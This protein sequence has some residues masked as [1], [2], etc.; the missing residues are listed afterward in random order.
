MNNFPHSKNYDKLENIIKALVDQLLTKEDLKGIHYKLN[1][2]METFRHNL[3][4]PEV[5]GGMGPFGSPTPDTRFFQ[6]PANPGVNPFNQRGNQMPGFFNSGDSFNGA[7][8]NPQTN[9][10]PSQTEAMKHPSDDIIRTP[11]GQI[12]VVKKPL[13]QPDEQY[14]RY[15]LNLTDPELRV[16]HHVLTPSG[17]ITLYYTTIDGKTIGREVLPRMPQQQTTSNSDKSNSFNGA[18]PGPQL[19]PDQ[20]KINVLEKRLEGL[21]ILVER[22]IPRLEALENQSTKK[23]NVSEPKIEGEV[24]PYRDLME[25]LEAHLPKRRD[26]K[27][28][29]KGEVDPYR[30]LAERLNAHQFIVNNNKTADKGEVKETVS[31]TDVNVAGNYGP[32]VLGANV[33]Y[34]PKMYLENKEEIDKIHEKLKDVETIEEVRSLD[35]MYLV[36]SS[37]YSRY[38]DF[39]SA[40]E[41]LFKLR[42]G[43][44]LLK[45]L[46]ERGLHLTYPQV[47]NHIANHIANRK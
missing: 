14:I 27:V 6:P 36:L 4:N 31:K 45:I 35:L 15:E 10:D 26:T 24:D 12:I 2:I 22:V 43:V 17:Y 18:F 25:R 47:F 34:P 38:H 42:R 32:S 44:G 1:Q 16:I 21:E 9:N 5:R 13:I 3:S 29:D 7:F 46:K 20:V 40:N 30:D 28:A 23:V 8:R 11:T 33:C 41:L 19:T 39:T 37:L